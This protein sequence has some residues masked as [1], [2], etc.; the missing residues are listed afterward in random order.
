M[1]EK[2]IRILGGM[3]PEATL[4]LFHKI[5]RLS[6]VEKDQDHF[7]LKFDSKSPFLLS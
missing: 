1:N 5:I 2:I 7:R 4:D 3:G 6:P